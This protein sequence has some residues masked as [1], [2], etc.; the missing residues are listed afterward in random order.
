MWFAG[1]KMTSYS[2][3]RGNYLV[4]SWCKKLVTAAGEVITSFF[5]ID[6]KVAFT[7][8]GEVIMS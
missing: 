5:L 6:A 4:V 7:V 3:R 2:G 8:A 1:A